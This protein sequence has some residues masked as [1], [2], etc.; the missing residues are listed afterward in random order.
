[1]PNEDLTTGQGNQ[2]D[3]GMIHVIPGTPNGLDFTQAVSANAG[4]LPDLDVRADMRFG[5]ALAFGRF[6]HDTQDQ[7]LARLTAGDLAVGIP[8]VSTLSIQR[9]GAVGVFYRSEAMIFDPAEPRQL[10]LAG[11]IATPGEAFD[12]FG[13]SLAAGPSD[14]RGSGIWSLAIGAPY[15]SYGINQGEQSTAGAAY[16]VPGDRDLGLQPESGR[17]LQGSPNAPCGPAVAHAQFGRALAFLPGMIT[18]TD[19]RLPSQLAVGAPSHPLAAPDGGAEGAVE[20]RSN[21]LLSDGF[22]D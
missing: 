16:V 15:R 20:L 14:A 22:E 2:A 21:A 6:R 11:I 13:T 12:R 8:G 19:D 18:D 7:P 17:M 1:M 4:F 9:L 3:A 5:A 10:L